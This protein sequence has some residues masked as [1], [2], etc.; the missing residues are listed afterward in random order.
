MMRALTKASTASVQPA[1]R[2]GSAAP[3]GVS[4]IF[5]LIALAVLSLA[6]VAL[7]RSVDTG[8]AVLGN[9]GFKQDATAAADQGIEQAVGWLNLNLAL[10]DADQLDQG[11]SASYLSALDATGSRSSLTTRVVVD[12][13][14]NGCASYPSGSFT[15]G[16]RKPGIGVDVN[17]NAVRYFMMRLCPMAGAINTAGND[18]ASFASTGSG[19]GSGNGSD[20]GDEGNRGALDYRHP[21]RFKGPT[22]STGTSTTIGAYYRI[23][24]RTT[25]AKNSVGFAEAIIHY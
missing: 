13:D 7:I 24:V 21:D 12:W 20:T 5:S 2:G 14:D 25:G 19:S 6:A 15:G 10:T 4:L 18:C 23:I 11:Y 9:L 1:M 16:C 17:G 3:R 8:T 22:S